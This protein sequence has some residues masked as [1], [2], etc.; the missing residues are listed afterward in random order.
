[1]D[2]ET[3]RKRFKGVVGVTVT[4][5][6][7]D[8]EVDYGKMYNLTQWW[9]ENGMVR[10]KAMLKVAS[11]M[12]EFQQLRDNE[13][14]PLIRSSV[15]AADG[16]VDIIAGSQYKDTKRTIEDCLKAS[17]LGAFGIQIAPPALNDPNQDDILRFYSDVSDAV[18]IGIMIYNTPWQRHGGISSDTLYKLAQ[19]ENIVALKWATHEDCP[20]TEMEGLGKLF[21]LIENGNDRV[22]FHKAGGH[23]FLDISSVA[24]PKHELQMWDLLESRLY[25]EAQHLWDSV[26]EPLVAFDKETRKVSGGQARFKKMLMNAMGHEVGEQRA[27]TLPGTPKEMADLKNLL[28][29]LGWPAPK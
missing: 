10:G 11:V 7:T 22:A 27:P 4:P 23:G 25:E 15:Q 13:W 29:A 14:P 12:G 3:R 19:F 6:D 28:R 9:V 18:D 16:K 8:Y 17:D 2:R 20:I 24:Y 21:N 26:D 1:M 5:F